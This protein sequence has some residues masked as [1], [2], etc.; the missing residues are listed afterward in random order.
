LECQT[1]VVGATFMTPDNAGSINRT[2]TLQKSPPK[3]LTLT[4][5]KFVLKIREKWV[6][7]FKKSFKGGILWL[8]QRE[9]K[10]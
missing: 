7:I 6:I 10:I 4:G 3:F 1:R 8:D 9:K 2:P 5:T